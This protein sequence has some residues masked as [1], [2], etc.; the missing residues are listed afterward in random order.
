MLKFIHNRLCFSF[1]ELWLPSMAHN[2][3]FRPGNAD[4]L[5]YICSAQNFATEKRFPYFRYPKICN[6]EP[7][8]KHNPSKTMFSFSVKSVLLE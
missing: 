4:D 5:K 2:P 6:E 1:N 8:R 7:I 3:D